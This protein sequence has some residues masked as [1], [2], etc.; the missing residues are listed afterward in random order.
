MNAL[1]E[2]IAELEKKVIEATEAFEH[3]QSVRD[4]NLKFLED[5][6]VRLTSELNALK[7]KRPV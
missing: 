1:S 5:E 7:M 6:L 4:I 2:Q 3:A